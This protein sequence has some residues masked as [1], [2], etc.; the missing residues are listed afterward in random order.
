MVHNFIVPPG[1][2][3]TLTCLPMITKRIPDQV[4]ISKLYNDHVDSYLGLGPGLSRSLL[5]VSSSVLD[6][7]SLAC[8]LALVTEVGFAW[9]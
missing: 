2:H 3:K 1:A 4:T 7:F 9:S 6:L 8:D 5:K